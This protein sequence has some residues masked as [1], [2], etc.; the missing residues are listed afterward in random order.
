MRAFSGHLTME[1]E[2]INAIANAL[3]DLDRRALE[4]R[5]YL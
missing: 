1:A 3:S 4:I 2:R 5:R